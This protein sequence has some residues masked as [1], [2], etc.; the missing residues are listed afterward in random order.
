[1]YFLIFIWICILFLV[2]YFLSASVFLFSIK[3]GDVFL[4]F[5]LNL[6][7]LSVK[8]GDVFFICICICIFILFLSLTC[9]SG[10]CTP[11]ARADYSEA[12][13]TSTS[14]YCSHC[15]PHYLLFRWRLRSRWRWRRSLSGGRSPL[16]H[17]DSWG[18]DSSQRRS[19][20]GE[21]PPSFGCLPGCRISTL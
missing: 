15:P 11:S 8:V 19:G 3:V 14:P 6:Y 17:L 5:H 12:A 4:D 16:G 18:A 7:S 21:L 1:M 9:P 2:M 13:T 20:S 10:W